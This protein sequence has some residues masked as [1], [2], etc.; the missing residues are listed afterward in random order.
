MRDILLSQFKTPSDSTASPSARVDMLVYLTQATLDIIGL[1]GF[2]YSFNALANEQSD[3][4]EAFDAVLHPPDD[5]QFL[6]LLKLQIPVLRYIFV[7]DKTTRDTNRARNKMDSIG[8]NLIQRKKQE[9]LEEKAAGHD[10][11]RKSKDLLSLMIRSNMNE[12]GGGLTEDEV[13]HQIPTFLLAGTSH[14]DEP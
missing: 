6:Q 8:R 5:F 2:N 10:G 14:A 11:V 9:I 13:L 3:L 4:S 1:A 7:F 12:A